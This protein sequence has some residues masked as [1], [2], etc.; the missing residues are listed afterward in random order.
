[1]GWGGTQARGV[2]GRSKGGKGKKEERET[3]YSTVYERAYS[4]SS[5]SPIWQFSPEGE[6]IFTRPA[7]AAP[8]K[9]RKGDGI[10]RGYMGEISVPGSEFRE[11]LCSSYCTVLYLVLGRS[12]YTSLSLATAANR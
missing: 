12:T 11:L 6:P 7:A 1:M 4:T 3:N 2:G 8:A 10:S 5:L 9:K